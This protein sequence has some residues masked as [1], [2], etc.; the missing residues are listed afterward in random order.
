MSTISIH[1]CDAGESIIGIKEYELNNLISL[2]LVWFYE[3]M[4][5][6]VF[7]DS[8]SERVHELINHPLKQ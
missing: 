8:D 2:G 1:T 6:Y 5:K 3:P 4:N 7:F